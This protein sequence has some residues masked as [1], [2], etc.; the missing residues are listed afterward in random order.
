MLRPQM[1][2]ETKWEINRLAKSAARLPRLGILTGAV[3][4][5]KLL[6]LRYTTVWKGIAWEYGCFFKAKSGSSGNAYF[7][8][9]LSTRSERI[10]FFL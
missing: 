9:S 7:I 5:A 4:Q 10:F 2:M 3:S 8:S 6:T 1:E